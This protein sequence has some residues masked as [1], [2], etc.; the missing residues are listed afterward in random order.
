MYENKLLYV[1]NMRNLLLKI[2]ISNILIKGIAHFLNLKIIN[3]S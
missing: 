3:V 1:I 2:E